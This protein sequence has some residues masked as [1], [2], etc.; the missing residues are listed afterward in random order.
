MTSNKIV[1]KISKRTSDEPYR[2]V[3]SFP[4][5]GKV[6]SFKIKNYK[7]SVSIRLNSMRMHLI[8]VFDTGPG[9]S[10]VRADVLDPTCL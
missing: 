8:C 5:P 3:L 1:E 7:V 4:E 6:S 10:L 9:P 2:K